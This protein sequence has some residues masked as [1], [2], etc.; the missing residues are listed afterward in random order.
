MAPSILK[1][2]LGFGGGAASTPEKEKAPI[3]ALPSSWYTSQ[4]MFELERRAIFSKRWLLTTHQVRLP[5]TGNWLRYDIAGYPFVLVRNR[6]GEINGFHNVCRHRAFPVVTEEQ[7]KNSIF[8]CK[9]H[10]WSYGLNGNLAKAP[11]YQ[12][13]PGFDKTKNNLFPVHVHVDRNGFIWV[14]LDGGEKPEIPWEEDFKDIDLLP[15]FQEH[16]FDDY[17]FDHSWE[18]EGAYN[19][20]ILADNYNECYHCGTAH[21]DIPSVADLSAYSVD[22]QDGTIIHN[23]AATP[24][25]VQRGLKIASTYF[26]PNASMTVS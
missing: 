14:N 18:M 9:Y 24:E 6:Q 11:G 1:D 10:G 20:K 7:G 12:D 19:W 26:Y 25:Q 16:N 13:L 5:E 17:V 22:N 23:A 4:E 8:S 21:P 2:Y 15:R 3:R